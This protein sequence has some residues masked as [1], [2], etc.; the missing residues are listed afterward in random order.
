MLGEGHTKRGVDW[1]GGRWWWRPGRG[2][3]DSEAE[4]EQR[5]C[6]ERT[7]GMKEARWEMGR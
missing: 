1:E 7:S 4:L 5:V 3:A 2:G 6:R